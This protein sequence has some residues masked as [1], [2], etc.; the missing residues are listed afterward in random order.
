MA[1]I[2]KEVLAYPDTLLVYLD[3]IEYPAHKRDLMRYARDHDAPEDVMEDLN[4][5]PDQRFDTWAEV[6]A[7][8]G[9]PG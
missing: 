2:D 6:T 9:V 1:A 5:L 8:L 4:R 7:G 3:G